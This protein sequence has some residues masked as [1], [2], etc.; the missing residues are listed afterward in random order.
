MKMEFDMIDLGKM[1]YFLGIEVVQS[2]AGIFICQ[3]R[4]AREILARLNMT[5]SNYVRN[6]IVPG[7]ILS[8]EEERTPVDATK[9]KQVIGSLMYLIVTQPDLMYG[10][11]LISRYMANPKESHWVAVKRIL[12]YLKWT[13]EYGIFYQQEGKTGLTA[14]SDNN[15]AGDLDDRRSTYGSVFLIGTRAVSWA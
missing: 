9:F 4:Y 15:Y 7:T 10:V 2:N 11:S 3:I 8:R 13:I 14:Y 6:P 12:R 5:E 1:K